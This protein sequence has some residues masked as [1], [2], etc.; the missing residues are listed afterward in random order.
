[1]RDPEPGW[2]RPRT[3]GDCPPREATLGSK[4]TAERETTS[5][6]QARVA[7]DGRPDPPLTGSEAPASPPAAEASFHPVPPSAPW[8]PASLYGL[9]GIPRAAAAGSHTRDVDST[10]EGPGAPRA[11]SP[12][13]PLEL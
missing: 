7:S 4:V 3:L 6:V 9:G 5:N 8:L 2:P 12:P 13:R 1:M 11:G 10:P